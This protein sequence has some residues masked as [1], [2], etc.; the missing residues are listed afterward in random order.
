MVTTEPG[1]RTV[2]V[3]FST[4]QASW[5]MPTAAEVESLE[6][7]R[8]PKTQEFGFAEQA[9]SHVGPS[10]YHLA[11]SVASA[12]E[13]DH[14]LVASDT[15]VHTAAARAAWEHKELRSA[16]VKASGETLRRLMVCID[17]CAASALCAHGRERGVLRGAD[18]VAQAR[19]GGGP[20]AGT[21]EELAASLEPAV[22]RIAR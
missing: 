14:V 12:V 21:S 20:H 19:G 7:R 22:T 18:R 15:L 1:V 6:Q 16:R 9:A 5:T 11:V 17:T 4:V 2:L 8:H 10:G 13:P 3:P